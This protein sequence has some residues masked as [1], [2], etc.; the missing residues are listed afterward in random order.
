MKGIKEMLCYSVRVIC[1]FLSSLEHGSIFLS[2][3]FP[4]N[5][6]PS[7]SKLATAKIKRHVSKFLSEIHCLGPGGIDQW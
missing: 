1:T 5:F 7:L 6:P 2:P 3:S 4:D